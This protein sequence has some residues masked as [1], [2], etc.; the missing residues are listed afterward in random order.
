MKKLIIRTMIFMFVSFVNAQRDPFVPS[1][2]YVKL[3][4]GVWNFKY[5]S[6]LDI[7]DEKSFYELDF[8]TSKWSTIKVPSNWEMQGFAEPNY[9]LSLEDGLGLYRRKFNIPNNWSDKGQVY[10]RFE[11]VAFGFDFWV[12]GKKIGS[13][14]ASAFNP[15]VFNITNAL[16]KNQENTIAVKVTTK[17]HLYRFD[18]ND[19]WSLSGIFRDVK[20]FSVPAIHVEDIN[21]K[22]QVSE[23]GSV[24]FAVDVKVVDDKLKVKAD[25][26]N[27]AGELIDDVKLK[28]NGDTYSNVI[29]VK[30]PNL[31]TAETPTL[32]N[33]KIKVTKKGKLIQT[34]Q[35]KV[36][37][38]EI[39]V[40]GSVLKINNRPVKLRGV[41]HHDL[42]PITGRTLSEEQILKDLNLLKKAN[43]N[44]IR[45]SHY[46]PT[47]RF[48]ELCDEMGFYI[49]DEIPLSSRGGEYLK[50]EENYEGIFNR[51]KA[52][53]LRDKNHPSV[54]VWSVGNEN[55]MNQGEIFAIKKLKEI[56]AT[57]PVILPKTSG[58]FGSNRSKYPKDVDLYSAHYP[59][60]GYLEAWTT[61]LDRP[62]IFTEYA[63]AQGLATERIA[64]QW[65][66]IQNTAKY[67][68]GAIWHFHDQGILRVADSVVNKNKY[69]V[70]AWRD[71]QHYYD[72]GTKSSS[73]IIGIDGADGI[74]YADRTPQTDY[75]EVRKVYAPIQI[76]I[77]TILVTENKSS[78]KV[79]V[80]NRFDFKS[81][82]GTKLH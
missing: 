49:M 14:Y 10:I 24:N 56:D 28:Y 81:L 80:E 19:D 59:H 34:I 1:Q 54:I 38:R 4:N 5:I 46:P 6:G 30:T 57:R 13:S 12:N 36:G 44:F 77:D 16:R 27:N 8:D 22:T 2:E 69:T 70:Y 51:V 63:H 61:R 17:P 67:A 72:T 37:L 68:G 66:I 32:Y 45:T 55:Q 79:I 75:W 47:E 43:I 74:V 18:L 41:N 40:D 33:L 9:G 11:G 53:V 78:V 7:K 60:T 65:E 82:K 35:H 39:K 15:H 23:N 3:L 58:T 42:D 48:I 62:S 25:L 71:K 64:S 21:T 20:L 29:K 31:W 50:D 52:T 26:F 76:K 73:N